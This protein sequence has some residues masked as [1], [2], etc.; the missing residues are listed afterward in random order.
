MTNDNKKQTIAF[1]L[2]RKQ[3]RKNP[4]LFLED[5][6]GITCPSHQSEIINAVYKHKRVSVRSANSI[7][8]SFVV[9]ALILWFFFCFI[10]EDEDK[11][12]IVLFTAPSFDQVRENIYANVKHFIKKADQNIKKMFGNNAKFLGKISQNQTVCEIRFREKDYIKGATSEKGENKM[13]GKH[14]SYVLVVYDEAQGID[15]KSFSDY[16]GITKS[17]LVVRE[18]MIGNTTLP[19]GKSGRFYESFGKNSIFH[20]IKISAF[21]TQ[22]FKEVGL[23]LKDYFRE[24]SD[25]DYWRKKVDRYCLKNYK[26]INM[27]DLQ[28]YYKTF[29]EFEREIDTIFPYTSAKR[30]GNEEI[31]EIAMK[32]ILPYC[33][34]IVNPQEVYNELVECGFN[35]DSYE[36][37]TRVLAE[38]PDE[39]DACLFPSDIID[40]SMNSWNDP[41]MFVP[42]QKFM[43]IDVGGGVG[44][45]PTSISI[46]NGNK[47]IYREEFNL[48]FYPLKQKIHELYQLY[49]PDGIKIERDTYA[50]HLFQALEEDGLPM[51]GIHSG[52]G[53]GIENPFFEEDI[54]YT[55]Q[56]KRDFICKR[57]EIHW[58]FKKLLDPDDPAKPILLLKPDKKLKTVMTAYVYRRDDRNKIRVIPKK[59]LVRLLKESPNNL[60]SLIMACAPVGSEATILSTNFGFI[61]GH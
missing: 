47:E 43:G 7:G 53:A 58:H 41:K 51:I 61:S 30:H 11:N 23:E 16:K 38:F 40:R 17:G 39:K 42:G 57:D 8:K 44:K 20:Q 52:G 10:D 31:W 4:R 25:K 56:A 50:L 27:A 60:D 35:P 32:S 3:W 48:K 13:V 36:F 54:A 46:I 5:V 1:F 12:V 18:I 22:A 14:G 33:A 26:N 6:L 28:N 2:K 45:D 37:K 24:D 21:D 15:D 34:H 55:E 49:K 29:E 9:S 59:D 19:N